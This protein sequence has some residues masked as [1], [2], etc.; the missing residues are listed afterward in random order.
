MSALR[1]TI[2]A[3]IAASHTEFRSYG[4]GSVGRQTA[5][6]PTNAGWFDG[7]PHPEVTLKQTGPTSQTVTDEPE[8]DLI[9]TLDKIVRSLIR[10]R[11]WILTSFCVIPIVT[12]L[13]LFQLPNRYT[14][15]AT[16]LVIQQ[17]VPERYVTPTSTTEISKALETM[18]QEVLSRPR[19]L[20][21]IDELGLYPRQKHR[22]APEQLIELM[23]K[24]VTIVPLQS[25][26]DRREINAFN[27]SFIAD[28]PHL[29]QQV[30][31]RLTTLFIEQNLKTRAD[32]AQTTTRFLGEQ[33]DTA[34]E[35]LSEQEQKLRDFK[36][37]HLGELPEQQQGNVSILAGVQTQLT[38]V[39]GNL[40][41]A[42]QQKLYLESLISEYSR[43]G[44]R[45][46]ASG[47]VLPNSPNLTPV[48]AA[49]GELARLRIERRRLMS[50]YTSGHPDLR[51]IESEIAAQQQI[52]EDLESRGGNALS[53]E[54]N[55]AVS[56]E[57][58]TP[59]ADATLAQLKSQ[60]EANRLE[61]EDLAVTEQKLRSEL[62]QYQN[63]L[64]S[65]PIRE[66]QL[67]AILR[68]YE[69]V[70]QHYADLLK[71]ESESQLA[72]E[73][74]KQQE[75]QQFRVADPPNLPA[76]PSSPNRLLMS[77]A[78]IA[79]GLVVGLGLAFLRELKDTSFH[80]EKDLVQRFSMP[81]VIGIPML[82][83]PSESRG[84]TRKHALEWVTACMLVAAVGVAE[85]YVYRHG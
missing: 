15:Q 11:W 68:D 26:T 49:R 37:Q 38:N 79:G 61:I 74:E 83:T 72:T 67:T 69:L 55:T 27:I 24:D 80:A 57:P 60:L 43:L 40:N 33:L 17:Q 47:V 63:R 36:M 58:L 77:L 73:L 46:N 31:S 7:Q 2:P 48:Q 5:T 54:E 82:L 53:S 23:R 22:L 30:T 13:G 70:K 3:Q 81:I 42:R 84:R 41:R 19:L 18:M 21:I 76:K 14:S 59:E 52:I 71:K 9:E 50:H 75:G 64:N 4:S 28:E 20:G 62:E 44:E 29:A 65:T 16:L 25:N 85:F 39:M 6:S 34:R 10:R 51:R 78:S 1:D 8:G 45:R 35:K 32:Q 12:I 56:A 66:Q